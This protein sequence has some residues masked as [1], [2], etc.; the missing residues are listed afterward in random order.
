MKIYDIKLKHDKGYITI[1]TTAT[2]EENAKR[3]VLKSE[4]APE[5]AIKNIKV[6][7]EL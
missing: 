1:R 2:S 5:S 3:T 4:K 6:I 7:K